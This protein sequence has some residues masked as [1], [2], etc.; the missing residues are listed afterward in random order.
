ML[1]P[2]FAVFI[3]VSFVTAF[4][5]SFWIFFT[6]RVITGILQGGIYLAIWILMSESLGLNYRSYSNALWCAY[7]VGMCLMAL[8]SWLVS[9]WRVLVILLSAPYLILMGT[10]R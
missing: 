10:Y 6:L 2:A 5:H 7:T 9:K 8:Q 3:V 4:V 1:F